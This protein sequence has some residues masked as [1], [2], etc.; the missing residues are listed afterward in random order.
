M[1]KRIFKATE[2]DSNR[3]GWI[4]DLSPADV[5]NPDCYWPWRTQQQARAFVALLD[6]GYDAGHAAYMVQ[7]ADTYPSSGRSRPRNEAAAILGKM[8]SEAKAEAARANGRKGGRPRK[9]KE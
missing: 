2:I 6:T 5:V 3:K 1:D 7:S 9:A 8:T 4:A